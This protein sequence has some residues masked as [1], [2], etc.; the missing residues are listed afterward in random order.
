MRP[1]AA[2][3]A[4]LRNRR[5]TEP[6]LHRQ[7]LFEQRATVKMFARPEPEGPTQLQKRP[8]ARPEP[9]QLIPAK[10]I[11]TSRQ[12]APAQQ[13]ARAPEGAPAT[14]AV[15]MVENARGRVA[16]AAGRLAG[17]MA[18]GLEGLELS[19]QLRRVASPSGLWT[20]AARG[21]GAAGDAL[22]NASG[23]WS[24]FAEGVQA[25]QRFTEGGGRL[26]LPRPAEGTS[27]GNAGKEAGAADWRRASAAFATSS[28]MIQ[29]LSVA[30]DD[31]ARRAASALLPLLQEHSRLDPGDQASRQVLRQVA[32]AASDLGAARE[33]ADAA[34]AAR[35]LRSAGKQVRQ[36]FL[37]RGGGAATVNTD[38]AA[39]FQ[40]LAKVVSAGDEAADAFRRGDHR[41]LA[42]IGADLASTLAQEGG[43]R[44][45]EALALRE[46]THQLLAAGTGDE[47]AAKRLHVA[48]HQAQA[49]AQWQ[50]DRLLQSLDLGARAA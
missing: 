5:A 4:E 44:A 45:P 39:T 37:E 33:P 24:R 12:P 34:Q 10:A 42:A 15:G 11:A 26:A 18:R 22:R 31:G 32:D 9:T 49:G 36:L 14:A 47:A 35:A 50:R 3:Q 41:G 7:D 13:A 17:S 28:E 25:A 2:A 40:R 19:A 16:S 46:R 27:A 30:D 48:I 43:R 20:A 6:R 21:L 8:T 38:Q 23:R 29:S 1:P